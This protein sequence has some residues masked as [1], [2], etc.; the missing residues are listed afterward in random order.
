MLTNFALSGPRHLRRLFAVAALCLAAPAGAQP[1]ARPK[2]GIAFS[3]GGA[4]GCAHV[5]VLRVLEE[6]R[7]PVDYAAGTSMGSIIGGLYATGMS[8]DELEQVILTVD[9][10]DALTDKPSRNQLSFRR[11]NDD[12]RYLPDI[13]G[14]IGKGGLKLPTG[15]RSG[16]K[17]NYLLR[18]FTLPVRTVRDFDELP[19]PFRA[20]ATDIG[21][22][23]MVVLDHGDLSIALRASMAIPTA[24]AAVE[25]DGR[26]LVDG[27]ITNNV[28]VDVVRAMGADVVIAIDIGSPLFG[29]EEAGRSYLKILGQTLGMITRSN[30]E[31]R[32]AAADLVI[33]PPVADYGTMQFAKAAEIVAAG[34]A[35]ARRLAD[36]LRPYAL[37]EEDYLAWKASRH[38]E[39]DPIP[40]VTAVRFEGN[41]R[42]DSRV[43]A[44]QIRLA[45]GAPYSPEAA[46]DDLARLFGLG[47]FE[48]IDVDLEPEGDGAAVVYRMREKPW[49]PT[50]LRVGLGFEANLEGSNSLSLLAGI[51]W[52]RLNALGAEWKTDAQLGSETVI[53]SGFYQPL[54]FRTGWFF[55]P[56]ARYQRRQ[57]PLFEEGVRIA[58]L[59]VQHNFFRLDLGYLF[60]RYGE[61]RLGVERSFIDASRESGDVPDGLEPFLGRTIDRGGIAFT[62]V[63]DQLD[64]ARLPKHG[65]FASL[66][67]FQGLESLGAEE[68]YTRIELNTARYWTREKNTWF[69]QLD[70]GVSPDSV[71]PVYDRFLLGGL[72]SL[73]GF[74]TG[75]LSGDNYGVVRAGYYR[76][77]TRRFHVGGYGEAARVGDEPD[78]L[79][80]NPVLTITGLIVADTPV[81]P[82]YFGL[83][84]AEGGRHSIYIQYGRL[85]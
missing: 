74:E 45:P 43:L 51:N 65:G 39:P 26:L 68:E 71:L 31:P 37:S 60:G 70:G 61:V 56:S 25:V 1:A 22:G 28:P 3:G 14:G 11:K 24:F 77:L 59:D 50:Y 23:Q 79:L 83:A 10:T 40:V 62:G 42:V 12:L 13:E 55:E 27:G 73:S 32:L 5:G 44:E 49:G 30:M 20:V 76:S 18:R 33:T 75:E 52:T 2:I 47:D 82:L 57:L 7:V 41:R 6:L 46:N 4:K 8:V 80:E 17:L 54:S 84:S 48:S 35:E 19:V 81:G 58:E 34:E 15:L 85:F 64:N 38:R 63:V 29:A 21:N 67:A 72:F 69:G 53:Q 16:Q 36:Q 78:D 9:W 66:T